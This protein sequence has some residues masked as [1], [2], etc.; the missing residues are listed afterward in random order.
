MS[1]PMDIESLAAAATEQ[2]KEV[3][4]QNIIMQQQAR[5]EELEAKLSKAVESL[6]EKQLDDRA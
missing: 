6:N 2:L 3:L 4:S 1:D 5:I